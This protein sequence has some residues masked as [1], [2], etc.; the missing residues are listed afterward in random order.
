M[1]EALEG[2]GRAGQ[3]SV[4]GRAG[5]NPERPAASITPPGPWAVLF[6]RAAGGYPPGLFVE[7][8]PIFAF[9]YFGLISCRLAAGQQQQAHHTPVW[10]F[11][12][13]DTN[14]TP[15]NALSRLVSTEGCF[16]CIVV[17][18]SLWVPE[19]ESHPRLVTRALWRRLQLRRWGWFVDSLEAVC[20]AILQVPS[21]P[22]VAC[23]AL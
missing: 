3:G 9:F 8:P 2:E 14:T 15:R 4:R 17:S 21:V 22:A 12:F 5:R 18:Y 13:R 7:T 19:A 1:P 20:H 6:H 23:L 10:G 11:A 16:R